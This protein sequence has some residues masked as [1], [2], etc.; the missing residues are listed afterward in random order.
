MGKSCRDLFRLS[1]IGTSKDILF[2][3]FLGTSRTICGFVLT[4][5]VRLELNAEVVDVLTNILRIG[6]ND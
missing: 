1:I 6:R 2:N 4:Y 5:C 3:I